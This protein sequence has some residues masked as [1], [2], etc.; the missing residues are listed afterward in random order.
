ML[1]QPEAALDRLRQAAEASIRALGRTTTETVLLVVYRDGKRYTIAGAESARDLRVGVQQVED[2]HFYNTAT[3]RLLLALL[4]EPERER[5]LSRLGLPTREI[6]S[7]AAAS[8]AALRRELAAIAAAG[9]TVL[10]KSDSH[11]TA[12]AVPVFPGAVDR[13]AALGLYYPAVRDSEVR[14]RELTALLR[15]GA[16]EIANNTGWRMPS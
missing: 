7:E 5:L 4:P 13:I 10:E 9:R 14:R 11:I 6:W 1:G 12:L 8:P 2:E 3:G 15:A 16:T